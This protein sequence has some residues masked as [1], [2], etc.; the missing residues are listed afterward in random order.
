MSLVSSQHPFTTNSLTLSTE[1]ETDDNRP[2]HT[3]AALS[4]LLGAFA[5]T[6]QSSM[7]RSATEYTQSGIHSP[8]PHAFND[9]QSED[10]PADH[11]S[12]AQYTPQQEVRSNNY[13][14]SATPTSEYGIYPTSARS[15]SFPEHIQ[16]QYHPASNHSGSS[17]GMA[18]STSPSMPLQDGRPNDHNTQIK[19]DQDV[20]IDPSIAASSPTYPAH[21]GGQYSPY[22]P[23][24]E[25]QHGYPSHPAGAMYAQPRPDW[26]GYAGQPQHPMHGGYAV[27]GAQPP[28]S[29]APATRSVSSRPC[30]SRWSSNG[31]GWSGRTR[32]C[33]SR[34][35]RPTAARSSIPRTRAPRRRRS[36]RSPPV[37]ARCG[38]AC[39]GSGTRR[40]ARSSA[41]CS[42]RSLRSAPDCVSRA[43]SAR[44]TSSARC[45]KSAERIDGEM[46]IGRII[47]GSVLDRCKERLAFA[48]AA[49]ADNPA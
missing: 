8:Y 17:G 11:A 18:Q 13:S 49:C 16:R 19:S 28:T 43:R 33:R 45:A 42:R 22:P 1:T 10:T 5:E 3:E 40:A 38:S 4:T 47:L 12:A 27:T 26:A 37:T 35:R 34:T 6:H 29:A 21:G 41:R 20:P 14:T 2:D 36:R 32:H 23:Q 48:R 31:S 9:A 25:M 24:Q 44:A 30:S 39:T 15:G 7:D 46:R